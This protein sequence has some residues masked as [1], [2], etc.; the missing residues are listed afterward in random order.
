MS[1]D[2][3]NFSLKRY[4]GRARRLSVSFGTEDPKPKPQYIPQ[5]QTPIYIKSDF[6]TTD[7][8]ASASCVVVSQ[9]HADE[10]EAPCVASCNVGVN[11]RGGS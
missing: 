2:P 3:A 1:T 9:L 11:K 8:H 10:M 6:S 5:T 7:E 4:S